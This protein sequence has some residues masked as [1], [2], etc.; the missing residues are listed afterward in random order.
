MAIHLWCALVGE[1]ETCLLRPR[2][3]SRL[4]GPLHTM[5]QLT[6]QDERHVVD[7]KLRVFGSPLCIISSSSWFLGGGPLS[8]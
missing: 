4:I 6:A 7:T 3:I 2:H 1:K 5:R 8:C